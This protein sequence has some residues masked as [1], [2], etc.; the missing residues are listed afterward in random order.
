MSGARLFAV[1]FTILV[2]SMLISEYRVDASISGNNLLRGS[3]RHRKA[4]AFFTWPDSF[5]LGA[6]KAC[7]TGEPN[8][9]KSDSFGGEA[10]LRGGSTTAESI[11]GP[12]TR[13]L[14]QT[15][16]SQAAF[17]GDQIYKT[18]NGDIVKCSPASPLTELISML[19]AQE[20]AL[21]MQAS[22]CRAAAQRLIFIQQLLYNKVYSKG[23]EPK[24][25][26]E[27]EDEVVRWKVCTYEMHRQLN[28][29]LQSA[30]KNFADLLGESK[31]S[32]PEI[33]PAKSAELQGLLDSAVTPDHH[34]EEDEDVKNAKVRKTAILPPD[35]PT[36]RAIDRKRALETQTLFSPEIDAKFRVA[37]WHGFAVYGAVPDASNTVFEYPG[38]TELHLVWDI[39]QSKLVGE[40]TNDVELVIKCVLWWKEELNHDHGFIPSSVPESIKKEF[41]EYCGSFNLEKA[42]KDVMH[43]LVRPKIREFVKQH[44]QAK[45]WTF[46]NKDR[47]VDGQIVRDVS[48]EDGLV[49]KFQANVHEVSGK[50][51]VDANKYALQVLDECAN[52]HAGMEAEERPI[53]GVRGQRKDLARVAKLIQN[54]R[55]KKGE[56]MSKPVT[57]VLLDDRKQDAYGNCQANDQRILCHVAPYNA[58]TPEQGV[59]LIA[60]MESILPVK[61][62]LKFYKAFRAADPAHALVQ[63]VEIMSDDQSMLLKRHGSGESTAFEYRPKVSASLKLPPLP[64]FKRVVCRA[65]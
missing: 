39:D 20:S 9:V 46:T 61:T 53:I 23:G 57:I 5:K 65:T 51:V 43:L 11:P 26:A 54:Q 49:G 59:E 30:G 18:E 24:N 33:S 17:H 10:R 62:L 22:Q 3:V 29:C 1:E 7:S 41:R 50:Q 21:M 19:Q 42:F 32:L 16:K 45:W 37:T 44:P 15:A 64:V 25:Q 35:G 8:D 14:S 60:A 4:L 28:K 6:K 13:P 36:I 27:V 2:L 58:I 55:Q 31:I 52:A 34:S 47:E 48:D 12:T 38:D 63:C 40:G 56:A